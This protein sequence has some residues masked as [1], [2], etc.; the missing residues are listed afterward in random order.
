MN[1]LDLVKEHWPSILN[2][3]KIDHDL[4]N[5]SF[6]SWLKPLEIKKVEN[7]EQLAKAMLEFIPRATWN[8][9]QYV[10]KEDEYKDVVLI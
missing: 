9:K 6:E 4:S 8:K 2:K 10:K 7:S 5:I 3:I 1:H